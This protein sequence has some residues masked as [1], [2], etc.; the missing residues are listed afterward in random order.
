MPSAPAPAAPIEHTSEW[1]LR[2]DGPT[3]GQPLVAL[4]QLAQAPICE[5]DWFAELALLGEG[6]MKQRAVKRA[7]LVDLL[8]G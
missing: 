1:R 5:S 4:Q 6:L 7:A 8:T 3:E 2:S